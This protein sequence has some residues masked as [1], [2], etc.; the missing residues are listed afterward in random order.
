MKAKKS[1]LATPQAPQ[2]IGPYS[3][4]IAM[5]DMI[6]VSGQIGLNPANGALVPGAVKEQTEMAMRNIGAV[7]AAGKVGYQD[8]VKTTVY[9]KDLAVFNEMNEI[10]ARFFTA[11]FPA[12]ATVQVAALPKDALVEI[13]AIA[14]RR[15]SGAGMTI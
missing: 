3:Q 4:G 12:R 6:F 8:V 5:G 9:L 11:P 10:Y 1:V 2:A 13:E 15:E 14:V 7:L